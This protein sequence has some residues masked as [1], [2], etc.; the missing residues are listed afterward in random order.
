VMRTYLRAKRDLLNGL[1][2]KPP[3][4]WST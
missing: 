2:A 3:A 1:E 4:S